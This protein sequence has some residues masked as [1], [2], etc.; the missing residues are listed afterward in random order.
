MQVPGPIPPWSVRWTSETTST[1]DDLLD[2][3]VQG[4]AD[5]TVLAARHQ[6][7]GRGRLD[8]RWDAPAD[9]NL[10][11]SLLFRNVPEH[12]FELTQRV[13]LAA[14]DAARTLSGV[15]ARLKW[16]ND[17][18][19]GDA[20]LAG[21]LAQTTGSLGA[22]VVGLGM[23]VRWCP[24]DAAR[25]G[26]H[27][28]PRD[29]LDEVL[30]ALDRQPSDIRARYRASLATIG[31][32]VEV[33]TGVAEATSRV[34]GTAVDVDDHGR[35]VVRTADDRVLAVASGDVVHARTT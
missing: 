24:P 28:D 29:V 16:P 25:L 20:K 26:E 14:M 10:L 27:L 23:N 2:A 18:L 31:R 1:N 7:A 12:P 35:L 30:S 9:T 19:V 32:H 34:S 11:V 4:A 8:R 3:A 33:V 15:D 6:T 21:I 17:V 5:R 22:V 13:G